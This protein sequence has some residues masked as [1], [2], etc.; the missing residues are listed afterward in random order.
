MAARRSSPCAS[1]ADTSHGPRAMNVRMNWREDAACG[2]ADPD[3]FFPIGTTGNAL[4]QI[5]EAACAHQLDALTEV[6]RAHTQ[7]TG[8][9]PEAD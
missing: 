7:V 5:D 1:S 8:A 4:R 2:D 3:L 9:P 6:C